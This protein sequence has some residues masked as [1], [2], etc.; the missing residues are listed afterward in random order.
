[1][2]DS[3]VLMQYE[4]WLRST[5]RM[6]S[7]IALRMRHVRTLARK[8]DLSTAS[9]ADLETV[10]ARGRDLASETRKSE[11]ASWRL[12]FEWMRSRGLRTD[13]P[14][15]TLESVRVRTRL[16]RVA[17]DDAVRTALG[18]ASPRDRALI[19][20][21]RFACLR[22]TELT[23]LQVSARDRDAIR[24]I[25]K[26]DKERLVYLNDEVYMP[27]VILERMQPGEPFY[28]PG[29]AA[30]HLH[31][32]SV[33]K[34]I[35]R[36]TGYNPHSLRHAGATAAYR[37]TGDLRAVQEMLGHASLATTQRY[38][39]LDDA[40]RRRVA[41]GTSMAGHARIAA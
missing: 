40:A 38:L 34:I 37:A 26:G 20:L 28:F 31:P 30:G 6:D 36:E 35:T 23:T 9:T 21:A 13:D 29:G 3:D 11:L 16:P 24:V 27:L 19:A 32:M 22:L 18:R 2:G 12:F 17:P 5:D 14:T 39:H 41:A 1:M 7:T 15:H 4:A 25:G 10:K 8:V 33:N